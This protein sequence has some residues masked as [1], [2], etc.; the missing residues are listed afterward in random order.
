MLR[1]LCLWLAVAVAIPSTLVGPWTASPVV[2][3][4]AM[5]LEEGL[6]QVTIGALDP[7]RRTDVA[8]LDSILVATTPAILPVWTTPSNGGGSRVVDTSIGPARVWLT[9]AGG[10]LLQLVTPDGPV[11]FPTGKDLGWKE[12]LVLRFF[13]QLRS[14]PVDF[15]LTILPP[16][17][18]GCSQATAIPVRALPAVDCD[19]VVLELAS[20]EWCWP[21]LSYETQVVHFGSLLPAAYRP[22]EVMRAGVVVNLPAW[23]SLCDLVL[24]PCGRVALECAN[25][26]TTPVTFDGDQTVIY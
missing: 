22:K 11:V 8:G 7:P 20:T 15:S 10:V 17:D 2:D 25:N 14:R 24:R 9:P 1:L 6:V 4:T 23:S 18:P 13:P 21:N 19:A 5:D 12:P 26:M 16:V 3:V